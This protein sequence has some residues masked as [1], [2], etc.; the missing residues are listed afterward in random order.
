MER[1]SAARTAPDPRPSR[2]NKYYPPSEGEEAYLPADYT[3]TLEVQFN[4]AF[5][6]YR[7]Q[8]YVRLRPTLTG[9]GASGNGVER[10]F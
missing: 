10:L 4:D 1:R 2:S 9:G 6:A 8:N 5:D 3:R 7:Q